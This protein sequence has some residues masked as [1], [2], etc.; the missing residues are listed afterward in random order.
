MGGSLGNPRGRLQAFL[1][2][3]TCRWARQQASLETCQQV[4]ADDSARVHGSPSTPATLTT[5]TLSQL[6]GSVVWLHSKEVGGGRERARKRE[7]QRGV[8]DR[9]GER[10]C[11]LHHHAIGLAEFAQ[12]GYEALRQLGQDGPASG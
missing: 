3:S 6:R 5:H 10:E 11:W 2:S 1:V 7:R 12:G 9:S 4:R 8:G